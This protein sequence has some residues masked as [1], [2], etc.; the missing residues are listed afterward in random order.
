MLDLTDDELS[1]LIEACNHA[2]QHGKCRPPWNRAGSSAWD[3]LV[4]EEYRR[5][6]ERGVLGKRPEVPKP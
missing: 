4:R 5:A 1:A 6:R 2:N 3:K